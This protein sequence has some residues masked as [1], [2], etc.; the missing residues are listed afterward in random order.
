MRA[1]KSSPQSESPVSDINLGAWTETRD[2]CRRLRARRKEGI[3]GKQVCGKERT[4]PGNALSL[5][6]GEPGAPAPVDSAAGAAAAKL[7]PFAF[8]ASTPTREDGGWSARETA[9]RSVGWMGWERVP[10][11]SFTRGPF[12]IPISFRSSSVHSIRALR[13]SSFRVNSGRN[14]GMFSASKKS[15]RSFL[16]LPKGSGSGSGAGSCMPPSIP[17]GIRAGPNPRSRP[18][19]PARLPGLPESGLSRKSRLSMTMSPRSFQVPVPGAPSSPRTSHSRG[20][21]SG[22]GSALAA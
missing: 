22:C 19:P 18:P 2:T 17:I 3:P 16:R 4:E 10:L 13:S 5:G 6:E 20:F 12:G 9:E 15:I 1:L 8:Q 7:P 14:C 11:R 21:A